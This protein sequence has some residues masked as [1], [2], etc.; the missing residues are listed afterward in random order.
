[1]KKTQQKTP[2]K[3]LVVDSWIELDSAIL[4]PYS[5]HIWNFCWSS[6]PVKNILE[7]ESYYL[8]TNY[9][10][11][12]K[13]EVWKAFIP[14]VFNYYKGKK[15]FKI[16]KNSYWVDFKRLI[17]SFMFKDWTIYIKRNDDW[18]SQDYFWSE[19]LRDIWN[20]KIY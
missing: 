1:M 16:N 5:T 9:F 2:K 6:I 17:E 8:D 19:I 12:L 20:R 3:K 14:I 10:L 15:C 13:N 11:I 18:F 7:D 4:K